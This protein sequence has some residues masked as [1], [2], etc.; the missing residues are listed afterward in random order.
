MS[1]DH[2]G[3]ARKALAYL[4][5]ARRRMAK[6]MAELYD[7]SLS[8][9]QDPKTAATFYNLQKVVEAARASLYDEYATAAGDASPP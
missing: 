3:T 7:M 2:A 8:H 6:I 4:V 9:S 1:N 5:A